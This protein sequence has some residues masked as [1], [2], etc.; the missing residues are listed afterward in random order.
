MASKAANEGAK[1]MQQGFLDAALKAFEK[2]IAA[3]PKD[4]RCW[5]G[6][7]RAQMAAGRA[8]QAR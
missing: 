3:D 8:E 5:L 4:V 7:G 6:V 2:G 1:L